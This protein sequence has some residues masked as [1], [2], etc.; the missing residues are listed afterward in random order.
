MAGPFVSWPC[1]KESI[2]LGHLAALCGIDSIAR[3]S[4]DKVV[5]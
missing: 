5:T 1:L 4:K 2:F 3:E